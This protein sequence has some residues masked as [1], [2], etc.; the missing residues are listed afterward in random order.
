ML[1]PPCFTFCMLLCCYSKFNFGYKTFSQFIVE[2]FISLHFIQ[3]FI[4]TFIERFYIWDVTLIFVVDYAL[5]IY[6]FLP[7][8]YHTLIFY[9]LQSYEECG[10]SVNIFQWPCRFWETV[11][12]TM[13]LLLLNHRFSCAPG[14]LQSHEYPL[15]FSQLLQIH[16]TGF[17]WSFQLKR[18]WL[19]F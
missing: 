10:S 4:W 17:W 1:P 19:G 7:M 13:P 5:F 16:F 18:I 8:L 14:C 3:Y 2:S 11:C 12:G 15:P 6:Q 9:M